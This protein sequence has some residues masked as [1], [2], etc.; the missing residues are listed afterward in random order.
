MMKKLRLLGIILVTISMCTACANDKS[1]KS[2]W[3]ADNN[4]NNKQDANEEYNSYIDKLNELKNTI[5]NECAEAENICNLVV[6]VWGNSIYQTSDAATDKYTKVDGE[7]VADFNIALENIYADE[8][9]SSKISEMSNNS[10]EIKLAM[11]DMLNPPE[12]LSE[13]YDTLSEYYMKYT[14]FINLAMNPLGS[15]NSVSDDFNKIDNEA[16]ELY[17]KLEIQI[18][19]KKS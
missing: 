15:L 12:G 9:I 13:C 4:I 11:K 7:F 3:E 5:L 10:E 6:Q 14:E 8:E 18:P 2:S 1:D 16:L 19:N 17:K